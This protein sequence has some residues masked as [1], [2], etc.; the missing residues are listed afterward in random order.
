MSGRLS[1]ST[2]AA[3]HWLAIWRGFHRVI[4]CLGTLR[5]PEDA[6]SGIWLAKHVVSACLAEDVARCSCC[7]GRD[8]KGKRRLGFLRSGRTKQISVGLSGL[9]RLLS[10]VLTA[11]RWNVKQASL[12]ALV[13]S[14]GSPCRERIRHA[15]VGTKGREIERWG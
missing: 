10:I 12:K 7:G 14:R 5:G 9:I 4:T 1:G 8:A 6:R 2:K 3:E 11:R 15:L 13:G